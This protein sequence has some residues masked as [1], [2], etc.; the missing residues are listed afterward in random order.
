MQNQSDYYK[1]GKERNE[2]WT[3]VATTR[4]N[5]TLSRVK[6]KVKA[7]ILKLWKSDNSVDGI[8]WTK[9]DLLR[10]I[11]NV[12]SLDDPLFNIITELL[13]GLE[14]FENFEVLGEYVKEIYDLCKTIDG[15]ETNNDNNE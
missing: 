4:N 5:A 11:S 10:I 9:A 3:R 6:G 14:E 1:A 7:K 8:E 2:E 13:S 15:N 12:K